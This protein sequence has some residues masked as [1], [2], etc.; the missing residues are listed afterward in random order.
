MYAQDIVLIEADPKGAP[1]TAGMAWSERL[2]VG[3]RGWVG[4]KGARWDLQEMGPTPGPPP[5]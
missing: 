5:P 2:L 1:E 4:R 3:I